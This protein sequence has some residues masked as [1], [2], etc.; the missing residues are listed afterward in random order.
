MTNTKTI[1][2]QLIF[3]IFC[4]SSMAHT[5]DISGKVQGIQEG[6]WI[7]VSRSAQEKALDSA[8]NN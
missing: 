7:Y 1:T 4:S 6:S 5:L 8:K 3:L 2:L